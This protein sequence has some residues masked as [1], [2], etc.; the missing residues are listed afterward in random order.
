MPAMD[1]STP[2]A[3]TK[4]VRTAFA[5]CRAPDAVAQIAMA[6]G[7]E[8]LALV[9]FFVSP[10]TDLT[11]FAAQTRQAFPE[12]DVIGCTT[13][14]ELG[15]A[16]YTEGEIVA[17]GLPAA[18]FATKTLCIKDL[19]DLR[20]QERIRAMIQNR[21]ALAADHP[22]WT[23][24]FAFLMVD[25]L[26]TRED[27]L[28]AELALGLGP[29]PLFGGSAGD[30][31]NFSTTH[32]LHESAFH[33]NAAVLVQLRSNCPVQVFKTDHLNPTEQRMVVTA[34]NPTRRLVHQINAEPAAREYARILGKDPE[35]LSTFTFAAHPVVVRIGDQTHVRAI[36]RVADNGDLVFF[37]AI[38]EGVVLTLAE[39]EDMVAHLDRELST[40]AAQRTPDMILG[41]DCLLRR[42]EATQKQVT[43]EIS[44][45]LAKHKVVGFSTY[46]EQIN[47]MHV[48]QTFTGVAIYP[49]EDG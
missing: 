27:A 9:I 43:T 47:S 17:I 8:P 40:L 36:Q 18:H 2:F 24:E 46:G 3:N 15:A 39:P 44:R 4:I 21:N 10:A 25:G 22:D 7:P 1:A 49:P 35:Q 13:A 26:S 38:D 19:G 41:C 20:A 12:A 48:N 5:D 31:E 6:L 37:S 16:G 34:A 23:S 14:G 33:T 45:V 28:T 29:V 11:N 42:V 32:I 30:G